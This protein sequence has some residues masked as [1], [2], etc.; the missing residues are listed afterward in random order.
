M[1]RLPPEDRSSPGRTCPI[2]EARIGLESVAVVDAGRIEAITQARVPFAIGIGRAPA[3]AKF[4]SVKPTKM[5]YERGM[6]A[7]PLTKEPVQ[8]R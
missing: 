5:V 8:L 4:E 6:N 3:F 7:A 2:K 1:R